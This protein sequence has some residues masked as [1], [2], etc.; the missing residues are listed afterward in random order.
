M[1]SD[2]LTETSSAVLSHGFI[3]ILFS[4]QLSFESVNKILRS[5][6][7]DPECNLYTSTFTW[8]N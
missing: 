7:N 5:K 1:Q 4:K 2:H 8:N 6:C 3:I